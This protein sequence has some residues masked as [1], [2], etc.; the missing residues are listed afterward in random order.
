MSAKNGINKNCTICNK[1]YYIRA[2]RAEASKYCSKECWNKRRKLNNCEHC[3]QPIIS[4]HGK[5]YC[6][7]KCSHS[8]MVADKAPT[9]ID[10]KSLERN[11]AR[12]GK[13]LKEWRAK[14]FKRDNFTCKHCGIQ[15]DLQAHHIIEWSKDESKRFDVNNGITLCIDCHGKVHGVCFKRKEKNKCKCGKEI[16]RESKNCASCAT[17]IQWEKQKNTAK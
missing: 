6:S 1:E 3:K 4:Y 5:K 7:R 14:V 8:A 10:G 11:R 16:K 12:H 15:K 9:W 13:E 17:K 2:N